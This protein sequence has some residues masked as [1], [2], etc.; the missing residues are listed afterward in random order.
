MKLP[1]I[2]EQTKL[3]EERL[4]DLKTSAEKLVRQH[5]WQALAA[6][7]VIGVVVGLLLGRRS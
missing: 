6:A 4:A 7:A 2:A 5:T 3:T 1:D